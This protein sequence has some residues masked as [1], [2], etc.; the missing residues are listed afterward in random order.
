M[1]ANRKQQV[2]SSSTKSH[3]RISP[4]PGKYGKKAGTRVGGMVD[5]RAGSAKVSGRNAEHGKG[6]RDG[7]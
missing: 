5:W 4:A 2:K 3:G 6:L 1:P 7:R